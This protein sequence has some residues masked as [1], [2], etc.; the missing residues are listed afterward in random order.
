[1][2]EKNTTL[3]NVNVLTKSILT[4]LDL[5][6]YPNR[7]FGTIDENVSGD[8]SSVVVDEIPTEN[9]SNPVA[10]GG[11]KTYV[12]NAIQSAITSALGG[13]Y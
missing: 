7:I 4:K 8:G 6:Q 13:D 9:S 11:V 3:E 10:S 12:D 1:M 2:I 5:T